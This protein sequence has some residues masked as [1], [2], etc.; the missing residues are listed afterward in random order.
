[1]YKFVL[2]INSV[3]RKLIFSYCIFSV[4]VILVTICLNFFLTYEVRVLK[5]DLEKLKGGFLSHQQTSQDFTNGQ[6][7]LNIWEK[8]RLMTSKTS[9]HMETQKRHPH[10]INSSAIRIKR[11]QTDIATQQSFLQLIATAND[12]PV[13]RDSDNVT[14]IPWTVAIQHGEALLIADN[15]IIVKQDSYYMV[16]GQVLFHNPGI[17]MGHLIR[18]RK[19]SVSGME[20]RFTD[21]LRCLQEMPQNNCANTCYTAGIVKLER[22]DELELVIP[23]R[24]Q[25]QIS[26]DADSTFF[27]ILQLQ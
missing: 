10:A 27:G 22:E 15:K 25:A 6:F 2:K 17:V 12:N 3:S 16:F 1:M 19:S 11:E 21:L 20:H 26:M 18:R 4:L 8:I 7:I 13:L 9:Y 23:D 5:G 24:P 14:T